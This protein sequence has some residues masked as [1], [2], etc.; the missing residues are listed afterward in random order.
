VPPGLLRAG[1]RDTGAAGVWRDNEL[2]LVP[3]TLYVKVARAGERVTVR[4]A[5]AD[6][7]VAVKPAG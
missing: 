1:F 4:G 7:L 3:Y 5:I 2:R 6:Y